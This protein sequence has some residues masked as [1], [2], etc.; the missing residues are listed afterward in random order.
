MTL[1]NN[2]TIKTKLLLILLF[3]VLGLITF[4]SLLSYDYYNKYT[5]IQKVETLVLL[6]SKL[7]KL[8]HET[9]KERGMTAGYLASKGEKFKN[10]LPNQ[11]DISNKNF[12]LFK[13]FAKTIDF[14][15]YPKKFK[16]NIDKT[17]LAVKG[18]KEIR[19]K[20]TKLEITSAIAI[21]YYTKMNSLILNN[22]KLIA[23]LSTDAQIS[24]DIIAYANFLLSKER[25]GI[26]RAVV[27]NVLGTDQFSKGVEKKITNLISAQNIYM[28]NFVDLADDNSIQFYKKT[29]V[30]KDIK[31]VSRIRKSLSNS[32]EKHLIISQMKELVGYGGIIHNFK[33]YVIRGQFKY[34]TKIQKQYAQLLVL[35]KQYKK[36]GNISDDEMNFL[37]DIEDVFMDYFSGLGIVTEAMNNE[38]SVVKLDQLLEI[39]DGPAI[40]ALNILSN[41]LFSDSSEY[42]FTQITSKINKLKKIDDELASILLTKTNIIKNNVFIS[43]I[44]ILIGSILSIVLAMIVGYIISN[45]ITKTINSFTLGLDNFFA[46]LNYEKDDVDLL[47]KIGSD[48]FGEMTDKVN[49]NIIMTKEGIQA[50]RKVVD[51]TILVLSEFEQGDL[52]Q[53]VSSLASNPALQ[54]LTKLLN[55]MGNNLE[56]NIDGLLDVLDQYSNYNYVN[57]VKT[58]GIKEHLLKLAEGINFLGDSVTQMLVE[59]KS[60]GLTL[61]N[62]SDILIENV[63]ILNKNSNESAAALEETAAALEEITSTIINNTNNIVKMAGYAK[64]LNTSANEGESLANETTKSMNEINEEV[65]AISEAISVIDKIAFQTNILSLNAA[66]EAATAGEAG[67]GFAVVAQ[68]VRNLASR[69][70]EAA[71]EIKKLVENASKKANDGKIISSKM[72][73]GYA[74]LNENVSKTLE[75]ITNIE[76]SSKE[77]QTGIEQIN[78]AV[79]SLDQQTQE[80]ASI[81]NK[82]QDIANQTDNISKLIVQN[83]DEKEFIGKDNVQAKVF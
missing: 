58:N 66:V 79:T 62:S 67:R 40:V 1:I 60:N 8:V 32:S 45:K 21:S 78:D 3:P 56:E 61:N 26:E 72:I 73:E 54:E 7:S 81:S 57:K 34:K 47:E 5:S 29:L 75:L 51:D 82:T 24:R 35:I 2:A 70:A 9:Q 28:N 42:W 25:A 63:D 50:D 68:E 39:S 76:R 13:N 49:E 65:T 74:G 19:S 52:S 69:S 59:N 16:E 10:K 4:A 18:L 11:K 36:V 83:A 30:G 12:I 41:S 53:R 27:T 37:A 80:N 43:L 6:S 23:K 44:Y 31:E 77:Q 48:E 20:V 15:I 64:E 55:Q 38:K 33:N 71:N 17:I 46:F 22:V 14:D